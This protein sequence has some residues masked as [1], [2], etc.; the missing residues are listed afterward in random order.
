[1]KLWQ[2]IGMVILCHPAFFISN[3]FLREGNILNGIWMQ[4]FVYAITLLCKNECMEIFKVN[5]AIKINP[6]ILLK[7]A[8]FTKSCKILI[9]LGAYLSVASYDPLITADLME[10]HW[11]TCM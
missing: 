10:R 7:V 8:G 4:T 1:M 6:A 9:L 3:Y 2:C 5:K 11:T